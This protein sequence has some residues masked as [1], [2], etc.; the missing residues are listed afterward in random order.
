[1]TSK[2]KNAK[3]ILKFGNLLDIQ[4]YFTF[5]PKPLINPNNYYYVAYKKGENRF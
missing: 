2:K 4:K 1:M 3:Q 5:P